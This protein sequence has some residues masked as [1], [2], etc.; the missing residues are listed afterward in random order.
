M[1]NSVM[2]LYDAAESSVIFCGHGGD[3]KCVSYTV[4]DPRKEQY[5]VT[6]LGY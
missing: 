5:L 6:K 4:V 2:S 1:K 3:N